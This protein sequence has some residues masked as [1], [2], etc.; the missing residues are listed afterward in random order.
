MDQKS[1][2]INLGNNAES[3]AE[4]FLKDRR[5]VILERNWRWK[6]AEIDLIA[7]DGK[8]LVMIEVKGRSSE[9]YG[10]ATG[11]V[12]DKKILFLQE[13][14]AMYASQIDHHWSIR[15]DLIGVYFKSKNG[16]TIQHIK[17]VGY[18]G[19]TVV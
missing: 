10:K 17:D 4:K 7:L 18:E 2:H 16:H 8:D 11:F 1:H 14:G 5:F 3:I 6:K 13:A 15:I 9:K 19:F 12:S